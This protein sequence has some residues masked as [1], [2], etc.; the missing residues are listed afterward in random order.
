M[1]RNTEKK[2]SNLKSVKTKIIAAMTAVALVPTILLGGITTTYTKDVVETEMSESILKITQESSNGMDH[3]MDGV[4]SQLHLLANNVN[5]TEFYQNP[6]NKIY[7]FFLLEGTRTTRD[8]YQNVYFAS[9]QKEFVISPKQD[10]P[11][12]YDPTGRDW[13]KNAVNNDGKPTFNEPYPDA[14]SKE[15]IVTVSQAV[16]KDGKIIGVVA[17]DLDTKVLAKE[18]SEIKVGKKGYMM[19][20]SSSGNLIIHPNKDLVGTDTVTKLDLWKDL[21]SKEKG[22]S[23]YKY[24]GDEKFSAYVTSKST[25]WKFVSAIEQSEIHEDALRIQ[26]ISITI[27]LIFAILSTIFAYFFGRKLANNINLVKGSFEQAAGGDLTVRL[28]INAN[29]E[30]KDLENSFNDM[31]DNLSKSLRQVEDTSQTVLKTA[32]SLTVMSEETTE[33]ISQVASAIGEIAQGTGLQAENSQ[34]IVHQINDLSTN[35]DKISVATID[36]DS[37][38][39]SSTELSE[40]GLIQVGQLTEKAQQTQKATNEVSVFVKEVS[41][42]MEEI[43]AIIKAISDITD[44][45][46]LLSLNASIESARAGEHGRGFAVVANEVR[47]LAEQSKASAVEIQKIVSNIK[48]VVKK[49]VEAM[50]RTKLVVEEQ[51]AVVLET[52]QIFSAILTSVQDLASKVA[53]VKQTVSSSEANKVI[54][55][56]QMESITAVSQETASAT[57]EVSASSEEISATMEQFSDY[58][59]GLK[60]LSEKLDSEIK[61][62][63]L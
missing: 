63:K 39:T 57:E 5:F 41:D 19:L 3:F 58:A 34:D 46:N 12:G 15:M 24:N 56:Q 23:S 28:N 1:S 45:T 47:N 52:K 32:S 35:L 49:A 40:K 51:D 8:D 54:V 30:F 10:L 16:K 59:S 11:E 36:M 50:D 2:R 22:H 27:T 55:V 18:I 6:D 9:S 31:M 20:V 38:S 25:G 21:S 17:V 43:N 33:S 26:N 42:H 14:I 48:S 60:G 7:G 44:Q 29:D 4:A 37:V 53:E 62:F 13:Y 61:K